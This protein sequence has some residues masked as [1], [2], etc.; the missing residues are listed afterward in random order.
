MIQ[1]CRPVDDT[2]SYSRPGADNC[3]VAKILIQLGLDP[4][5]SRRRIIS[6]ACWKLCWP[7]SPWPICLPWSARCSLVA[8]LLMQTM[9]RCASRQRSAVRFF[10]G[11]GALAG[12]VTTFLLYLLLLPSTP[13]VFVRCATGQE[14]AQ[15]D[16][17]DSSRECSSRS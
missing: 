10:A 2:G 11:F 3:G 1:Q 9:C 4:T 16:A 7:I 8:T 14:S 5:T 15:R 12:S 17:G 6:T 13:I